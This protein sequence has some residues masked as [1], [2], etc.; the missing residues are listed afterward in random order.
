MIDVS[1]IVLCYNQESTIRRALDSILHQ[2]T[3]Y[4]YEIIIGD[5]SSSDGT[6]RI[7]EEYA[8]NHS[9][10]SINEP[11]PNY[12]VVKNYADCLSRVKGR[13]IMEC[14]GDD[15]WHNTNKI[16]LQVN[17]MDS[18]KE[19]VLYYGGYNI[20]TPLDEKIIY[21]QPI[22]INR[23]AFMSVLRFNPICAPTVCIRTD[24]MD[25]VNFSNF[26]KEGFLVEDYP[27]WLDLSLKGEFHCTNE[28]LVTYSVYSGSIQHQTD[29]KRQIAYINNELLIK[30]YF[31]RKIHKLA[32]LEAFIRDSYHE[33]IATVSI[34]FL[35]R[36]DALSAYLKIKN[37][38]FKIWLK[39]I[40][41]MC[42]IAFNYYS[43][44]YRKGLNEL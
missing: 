30:E 8:A 19:C 21:S 32:E 20:Y 25:K 34:T 38:S 41:C 24:T 4:N 36:K 31:A 9:G 23:D 2:E 27:T 42:P 37:K 1:V 35:Q 29:Y 15:W 39:I 16:S 22:R 17:Y 43:T 18:H 3:N 33:H 28:A 7:C 14:A 10:I 40:V 11:H 26:L 6:R 44:R 12:G 13:Y 5:D